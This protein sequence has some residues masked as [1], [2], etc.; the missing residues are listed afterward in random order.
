MVDFTKD[1]SQIDE[2]AVITAATIRE[3]SA[4][5]IA[6]DMR[7]SVE[8]TICKVE[9]VAHDGE[10]EIT[11]EVSGNTTGD[12]DWTELLF[13]KTTA[14]TA[15]T[16]TLDVE[17]AAAATTIPLTATANFITKGDRYF[18]K[19][20]T[21]ANSEIVRNNGYSDGVSITILD[22]LTNTQQNGVSI[23]T[24]V[25]QWAISIPAEYRRFRVLINNADADCDIVSR[26]RVAKVTELI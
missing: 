3:G 16:T 5:S 9:A 8:V 14:E 10:A 21:I 13:V 25:E 20:G 26:T 22:G 23:Y 17:A 11:L 24:S 18:I 19:N 1:G 15:S 6:D 7:I 4:T 12:E 2:W